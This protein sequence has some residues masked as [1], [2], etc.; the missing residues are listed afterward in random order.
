[1]GEVGNNVFRR[2]SASS[3]S[4]ERRFLEKRV[5]EARNDVVESSRQLRAFQEEHQIIDLGEQSRAVVSAMA[6]LKGE[7]ISKQL[8]L[9]YLD[10][11]SASDESTTSQ[12]RRQLGVM[13]SK[14]RALEQG[15]VAIPRVKAK[16]DESGMF[17]PAISVPKLRFELEQLLRDQKIQ[18]TVFLL[19]TQRFETAKVN[20]ARDTSAF[21]VIDEAVVA[22]HRS[23]PKRAT[24]VLV[25][26]G[27]G[28]LL[29]LAWAYRDR[30]ARSLSTMSSGA[31]DA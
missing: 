5:A 31:A 17:P 8:Q 12:L 20:E 15:S 6:N 3:A 26:F 30:L 28:L 29:G 22:Q 19:L 2:V 13:E 18:E 4:E 23:R 27:I 9:S 11:F 14:L 7:L 10:S 25:G 1:M 21:Q 16:R 24:I